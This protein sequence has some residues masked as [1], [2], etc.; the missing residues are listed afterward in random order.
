LILASR[1]SRRMRA[2]FC[3]G[4]SSAVSILEKVEVEGEDGDGCGDGRVEAWRAFL[5]R[6]PSLQILFLLVANAIM[7]QTIETLEELIDVVFPRNI[8]Y[9]QTLR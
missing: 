1:R 4:D 7:A 8:S 2:C 5:S 3:A 9:W 6:C